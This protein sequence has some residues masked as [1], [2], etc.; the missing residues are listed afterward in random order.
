MHVPF[1]ATV[2]ARPEQWGVYFEIVN[3]P[4]SGR[5][6]ILTELTTIGYSRRRIHGQRR[7]TFA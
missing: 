1:E 2:W 4:P 3:C 7:T 6:K 5:R